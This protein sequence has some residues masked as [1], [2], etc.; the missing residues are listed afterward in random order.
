[1]NAKTKSWLMR[2]VGALVGLVGIA[3]FIAIVAPADSLSLR[4][5]VLAAKVAALKEARAQA[6]AA[7]ATIDR[8]AGVVVVAAIAGGVA[9]AILGWSWSRASA[10]RDDQKR[11]A[12][13]NA[14]R[15][16]QAPEQA[17]SVP[18]VH[19]A[20]ATASEFDDTKRPDFLPVASLTEVKARRQGAQRQRQARRAAH[21]VA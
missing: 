18:S 6:P 4:Q 11:A 19:V 7:L 16:S 8:S 2:A 20:D 9:L 3:I 5:Q 13:R 17:L 10:R 15:V 21:N 14:L 12:L 1:M